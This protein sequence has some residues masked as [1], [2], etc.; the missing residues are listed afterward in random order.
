Y[1]SVEVSC[2]IVRAPARRPAPLLSRILLVDDVRENLRILTD[3]LKPLAAE[4][5][6][7]A[8]GEEALASFGRAHFD[9]VILDL[10]LPGMTGFEL[11]RTFRDSEVNP[12]VPA[13]FLSAASPSPAEL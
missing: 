5:V 11:L 10:R 3:I 1:W 2:A 7:A 8:S 9:L 13:I 12:D 6:E 4:L